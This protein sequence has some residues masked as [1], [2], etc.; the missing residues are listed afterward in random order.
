MNAKPIEG[1]R[2]CLYPF[3]KK[4]RHDINILFIM[5]YLRINIIHNLSYIRNVSKNLIYIA[6]SEIKYITLG[7]L[8]IIIY[9]IYFIKNFET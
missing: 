2:Y 5:Y 7:A 9:K 3:C 8:E 1:G 4:R 6:L